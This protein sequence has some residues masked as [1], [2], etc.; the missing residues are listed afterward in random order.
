MMTLKIDT[1]DFDRSS[2]EQQPQQDG[3]C[4]NSGHKST[5]TRNVTDSAVENDRIKSSDPE[6]GLLDREN[7]GSPSLDERSSMVNM[8]EIDMQ[9][10]PSDKRLCLAN[11]Q[12]LGAHLPRVLD[13]NVTLWQFLLELLMDPSSNS[14]LISWTSADGEFKLHNSEEVARL[15]GLRKNKTN[16]NYDKLSRALRYYYDKNIIKKVNGQKFVYKFVSFPEII[17]TET[18]IPFRV[19][20]ER[21]TQNENGQGGIDDDDEGDPPSPTPSS[22]PPSMVVGRSDVTEEDYRYFIQR[23]QEAKELE[24][25]EKR[26]KLSHQ[27]EQRQEQRR[28]LKQLNYSNYSPTQSPADN[29]RHREMAEE[30]H[31]ATGSL[32]H[33]T[34][35]VEDVARMSLGAASSAA[36][37]AAAAALSATQEERA[38]NAAATA[39]FWAGF[40]QAA[41]AAVVASTSKPEDP[42][43]TQRYL[44]AGERQNSGRKYH[45]ESPPINPRG[46]DRHNSNN[47]HRSNTHS[48]RQQQHNDKYKH[49]RLSPPYPTQFHKSRKSPPKD[50]VSQYQQYLQQYEKDYSLSMSHHRFKEQPEH[51]PEELIN[52]NK[53]AL[54]EAFMARAP[55]INKPRPRSP[56]SSGQ[57]RRY[58]GEDDVM[59]VRRR[60]PSLFCSRLEQDDIPASSNRSSIELKRPKMECS[61]ISSNAFPFADNFSSYSRE[62][63]GKSPPLPRPFDERNEH[64]ESTLA[65]LMNGHNSAPIENTSNT[66][67]LKR[68][69]LNEAPLDL[70]TSPKASNSPPGSPRALS[71]MLKHSPPVSSMDGDTSRTEE[72]RKSPELLPAPEQREDEELEKTKQDSGPVTPQKRRLT[73]KKSIDRKPSPIDL[74]KPTRTEADD[75]MDGISSALYA[76]FP[77]IRG[78]SLLSHDGKS[79]NTPD[80]VSR[81]TPS[82]TN[83]TFFPT[84]VIM[85]PSPMVIP[86]ITFWSTLSPMPPHGLGKTDLLAG[87]REGCSS[88]STNNDSK[89]GEGEKDQK[90][91]SVFQF[92]T[93]VNGQMTFAGVPVRPIA[94]ALG[95]PIPAN[96][97]SSVASQ[98]TS[99]MTGVA[100]PLN[101]VSSSAVTTLT[102]S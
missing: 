52:H 27:N 89:D 28:Q 46:W 82:D 73:G 41:A 33:A 2:I 84:S 45:T 96:Q 14:H 81:K 94:A 47:N 6:K 62:L 61:D 77:G 21:L 1:A 101:L 25:A 67:T 91:G 4:N 59:D 68:N 97:V 39:A 88:K 37:A 49:D 93:V 22:S 48:Y 75:Y 5:E 29:W 76:Q 92:P 13:M 12:Q 80:A 55:Q 60:D 64:A 58:P 98:L 20:M 63:V 85:T 66:N 70:C 87:V 34:R 24:Q 42:L 8:E 51:T 72:K 31:H 57:K 56:Y 7:D 54:A 30:S 3:K 11:M 16:M 43:L 50:T 102:S 65:M 90:A 19:K 35:S 23:Q 78:S 79:I 86:S 17:K 36:A 10:P 74:S 18:K 15:W 32:Q 9:A 95:Q 99:H 100:S 69:S 38:R 71:P 44:Q 53:K 83:A 40:R 26:K